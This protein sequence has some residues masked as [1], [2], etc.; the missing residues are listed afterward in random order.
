MPDVD[1]KKQQEHKRTIFFV[2]I[3]IFITSLFQVQIPISIEI[4]VAS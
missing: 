3:F 4:F 1:Y 2:N